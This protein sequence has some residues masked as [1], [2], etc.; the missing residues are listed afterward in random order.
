MQY[1]LIQEIKKKTSCVM[2]LGNQ[3]SCS[4]IKAKQ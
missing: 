4:T 3:T 1:Y 2:F